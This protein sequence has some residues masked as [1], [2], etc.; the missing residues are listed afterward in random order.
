MPSI[1]SIVDGTASDQEKIVDYL[2][3]T[4]LVGILPVP[5]PILIR[6]YAPNKQTQ[7]WFNHFLWGVVYI[8]NST[9]THVLKDTTPQ[10]FL[11]R[12]PEDEAKASQ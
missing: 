5:H 1:D 11:I 8:R 7:T 2:R 6:H 3:K 9:E 10:L 4:T 12:S